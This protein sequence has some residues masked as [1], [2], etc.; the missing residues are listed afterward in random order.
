[1]IESQKSTIEWVGLTQAEYTGFPR[2][3]SAPTMDDIPVVLKRFTARKEDFALRG[4]ASAVES[5]L[6]KFK[7]E[8]CVVQLS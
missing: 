7:G 4:I 3:I 2:Y 5:A 1:M 8:L 6:G